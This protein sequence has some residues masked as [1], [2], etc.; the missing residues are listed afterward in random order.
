[1]SVVESYR[2]LVCRSRLTMIILVIIVV[3]AFSLTLSLGKYDI[4]I[5]DSY[6]VIWIH[7]SG[8]PVDRMDLY[9]VWESRLPRAITAI[10]VGAGL[11]VSGCV[12]QFILRNPLADP[13][14]TGLSSGAGLGAS[15]SIVLDFSII[16]GITGSYATMINAFLFSLIP[17]SVILLL[18]RF[19]RMTPIMMILVGIGLMYL[20]GACTT[21]VNLMANPDDLANVYEWN[22]GT[23]GKARWENVPF[24]LTALVVGFSLLSMLSRRLDIVSL[25]EKVCT[26]LGEDAP[27]NRMVCML[28]VSIVT[29][30]MSCFTGTIG[31]V[32][33][34]A[35]HIARR[36]V[37]NSARLLIP[38]SALTGAAL[39]EAA[40]CLA[41]SLG[42]SG[43]AVGI[44]MSMIGGP[45]FMVMLLRK[46]G[47]SHS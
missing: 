21:I 12:M 10:T 4:G 8:V 44:V 42:S 46:A 23:L 27:R 37:G 26:S 9:I 25:D 18:C 16:P 5:V 41:K 29:A 33:L 38:M 17:A 2:R 32:G 45:L 3:S 43:I 11:A 1:M 15:L 14:T 39:L 30:I 6:R 13:Y 22:V 28:I 35:P 47:R 31:F 40:D 7:I 19:R 34:V 20:F 36:F 24:T